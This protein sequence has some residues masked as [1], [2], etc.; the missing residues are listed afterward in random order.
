MKDFGE[1]LKNA[2][3][4]AKVTFEELFE[5]TKI[6][7]KHLRAIE[8][9]DFPSLPQTYIRA[10]IR[11]YARVV[12]IDEE[13]TIRSYNKLAE[14]ERGIPP[15]PDALDH[16]H[17]LPQLD[18][19]I[20]IVQP[21]QKKHSHVEVDGIAE[22]EVEDFQTPV[23]RSVPQPDDQ[24]K[25]IDIRTT[26]LP[27]VPPAPSADKPVTAEPLLIEESSDYQYTPAITATVVDEPAS[28]QNQ[29]TWFPGIHKKREAAETERGRKTPE[30]KSVYDIKPPIPP[31]K[32]AEPPPRDSRVKRLDEDERRT[33]LIGFIVVII[34]SLGIYGLFFFNNEPSGPITQ[35]DSTALKANP[36]LQRKIDSGKA[37]LSDEYM[38]VDTG[39]QQIGPPVEM[40]PAAKSGIRDD[41]LV[42]ETITSSPVWFQVKMDT[43]RS[44]RGSLSSNEHRVWKAKY[45][46]TIT[47][48]DAGAATF[49]LNGKELGQLG[50][51]GA[52]LKNYVL[53]R[54]NLPQR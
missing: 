49:F 14:M 17:I 1:K 11:E 19:S 22:V 40:K 8:A 47:L 12:G 10:F 51:D 43:A 37:M 53:T 13:E 44:E 45:K 32:S 7:P 9:G 34:V 24:Q 27:D 48:G 23:R 39:V 15:P 16:S 33:L 28:K 35:K 18:D 30:R 4:E 41:S 46:F 31:P 2:R 38:F 21:G 5:R 6:N 50:D 42:L 29:R 36:D 54:Q 3:I 25:T 52:V 26:P 20:E